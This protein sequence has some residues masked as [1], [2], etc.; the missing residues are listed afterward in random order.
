[1]TNGHQLEYFCISRSIRQGDALSAL[2]FIIQA[3]PL[4]QLIRTDENIEGYKIQ[5]NH[6]NVRIN[7]CQ[8]VDDTIT[9]LNKLFIPYYHDI[10]NKYGSV[11][12]V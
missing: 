12:G 6:M 5:D 2:L 3:E 11:S 10:V 1:M 8:Y 9:V 7:G 4:A